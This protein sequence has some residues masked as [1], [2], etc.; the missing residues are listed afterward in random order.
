ME[1]STNLS[2]FVSSGDLL[3]FIVTDGG[4]LCPSKSR[5][6]AYLNHPSNFDVSDVRFH[7]EVVGCMECSELYLKGRD[8]VPAFT[9][10]ESSELRAGSLDDPKLST[11]RTIGKEIQ[12]DK[13]LESL[14]LEKSFNK[15]RKQLCEMLR[16]FPS[17]VDIDNLVNDVYARINDKVIAGQLHPH[18]SWYGILKKA[19]IHEAINITRRKKRESLAIE[20]YK[21][22]QIAL[23]KSVSQGH[24]IAEKKERR[25][26]QLEGL[27]YLFQEFCTKHEQTIVGLRKKEVLERLLYGQDVTLTAEEMGITPEMVSRDRYDNMIWLRKCASKLGISSD[28]FS[29]VYPS[30]SF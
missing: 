16:Q 8:F 9:T 2:D 4:A 26:I 5:L 17:Y 1:N 21:Q 19:V 14:E 28:I 11:V 7:V 20:K 6:D 3:S 29:F 30:S 27:M 25:Q 15:H 18:T 22:T 10:S 24:R 12:N 13:C 23:R